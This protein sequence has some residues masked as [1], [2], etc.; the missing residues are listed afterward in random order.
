M[1]HKITLRQ[2]IVENLC[3]AGVIVMGKAESKPLNR[4]ASPK[5]PPLEVPNKPQ[6]LQR[7]REPLAISATIQMNH[8]RGGRAWV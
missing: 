7:F 6:T 5:F 2:R 4:S 3:S 1:I 8:A